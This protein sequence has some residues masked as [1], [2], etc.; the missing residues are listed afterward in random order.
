MLLSGWS[1]LLTL[2]ASAWAED[3]PSSDTEPAQDSAPAADEDVVVVTAQRKSA[4]LSTEAVERVELEAAQ[5]RSADLGQVLGEQEG[6]IVQRS[7]G[8]GASQRINL[9]GFTGDQIRVFLDGVPLEYTGLGT[10]LADVPMDLVQAMEVH[11][12]V[13]PIR[14]GA[15]ALGGAIALETQAP[16]A[17]LHGSASLQLGS[18]GTRRAAARAAWMHGPSGLYVEGAAFYDQADNDWPVD[19]EI[20]DLSGQTVPVSL[21]R[22][23][24]QYQGVGG[25]V[26]VGVAERPWADRAELR[27][28]ASELEKGLPHNLVMTIPYGEVQTARSARGATARWTLN[29]APFTASALAAWSWRET[30]F[31]DQSDVV[32]DWYGDVVRDRPSPGELGDAAER[33]T[34][35]HAGYARLN[36]GLVLGPR[37]SLEASATLQLT[38][39][40]GDDLYL[41]ND[42]DTR[43]PFE[44]EQLQRRSVMG[45]SWSGFFLQDR[46]Q[47]ELFGKG[48]GY[49]AELAGVVDY[50][51]DERSVSLRRWGAGGSALWSAGGPLYA[52]ASV[53]HAL[54]L[55][56]PDEVFGDGVLVQ[57]N[58]ALQPE[59]SLNTNLELGASGL[60]W[61]G[62][63]VDVSVRG[64]TR[65]AD[66]LVVLMSNNITQQWQNVYEARGRGLQGSVAW[67]YSE[68]VGLS[69]QGGWMALRNASESGSFS[70]YAG[71]LIPNRPT[72]DTSAR[73]WVASPERPSGLGFGADLST[74]YIHS[75]TR[76][77]ESAGAAETKQVIPSQQVWN[78]GTW[79]RLQ[80]HERGVT[81]S[82]EVWNLLDA[83]TFDLY[84]VQRPGRTFNAKLSTRW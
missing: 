25:R 24:G 49:A 14:L 69:A 65:N 45:L 67:G 26:V 52:K 1:I 41:G 59:R 80:P 56:T 6:V 11:H 19:V 78:A 66:Q 4:T 30:W 18:W 81:L 51:Y 36:A 35:Q 55:P 38:R 68:R 17:G 72:L 63:S 76:S 9:D 64:V 22:I 74:R 32:Y 44:T 48:Y 54:R 84:G 5:A 13:V 12:G 20:A 27:V 60:G 33:F 73:A 29:R 7:G 58:I 3:E 43:D 62:H 21:P 71:D 2:S 10:T 50:F 8:L 46:L 37:S 79:V 57:S 15:D 34:W 42:P 75:F 40:L 31:S 61:G 16:E 77:W 83:P 53:E 70:R 23:N 47:L 82:L 28:L 39:R